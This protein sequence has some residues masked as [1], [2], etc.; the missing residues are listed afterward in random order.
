M[1]AP[2]QNGTPVAQTWPASLSSGLARVAH[3]QTASFAALARLAELDPG[4]AFIGADLR[5]VDFLDDDLTAFSFLG[6]DLRCANLSRA[7]G[8]TQQ[9]LDGAD[10]RGAMLPP[11]DDAPY[12]AIAEVLMDAPA[13]QEATDGRE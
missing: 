3:A 1:S 2:V 4:S 12:A 9:M 7:R 6:A 13:P 10:L 5:G 8:V 11:M